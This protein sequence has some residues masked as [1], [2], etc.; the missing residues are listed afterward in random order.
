MCWGP[1]VRRRST[2]GGFG[3]AAAW[4]AS[5]CHSVVE[6]SAN[7]DEGAAKLRN[8][9]KTIRGDG[10]R[11]TPRLLSKRLGVC[12]GPCTETHVHFYV[13]VLGFFSPSFC[14]HLLLV[15]RSPFSHFF[16]GATGLDIFKERTQPSPHFHFTLQGPLLFCL[17]SMLPLEAIIGSI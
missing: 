9:P 7:A 10:A 2:S 4:C 17:A 11:A 8:G 6:R 1:T 16:T 3:G 15:F 12:R 14:F 13:V 5:V